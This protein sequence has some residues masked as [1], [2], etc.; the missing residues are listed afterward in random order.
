[1]AKRSVIDD[2][3]EVARARELVELGARLQVLESE[4]TLSRERLLRL[5]K[6]IQG[7]SPPKG[8]LPFSIDW[9]VT[10]LPNLHSS[11]FMSIYGHL[12]KASELD[13][14]DALTKAYRL[15]L[16]HCATHELS[17]ELSLTRAWRLIKFVDAGMLRRVPAPSAGCASSCGPTTSRT[18]SCAGFAT[19]RRARAR[20]TSRALSASTG[21][22]RTCIRSRTSRG[23]SADRPGQ[24]LPSHPNGC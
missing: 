14:V 11:L 20:R 13:D 15:Y 10:W 19:C 24:T 9:F 3:R 16:E 22:V 2:A 21:S 6:E 8:L 23:R 17:P 4:T 18:S 7:K 5:Y 12:I 1:M